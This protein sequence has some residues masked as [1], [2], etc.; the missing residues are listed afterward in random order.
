MPLDILDPEAEE[1]PFWL[2]WNE[3]AS[4]SRIM[5]RFCR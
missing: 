3:K 5:H 1:P 2:V 4:L